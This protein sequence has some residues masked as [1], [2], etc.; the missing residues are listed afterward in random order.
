MI[1]RRGSVPLEGKISNRTKGKSLTGFTLVE[2][3]VVI[4]IIAL[5]MSILMPALSRVRKQ[6]QFV[7]CR[8]NLKQWGLMF[9]FYTDDWDGDFN[10][11]W[12]VGETALWMNALR[13]YYK[14][15]W[16]LLLCPTA[17]V[18][19]L[20]P[21]DMGTF[22]AWS[23]DVAM[24]G[25]G[26]YHYVGSY[27]INSWTNYMTKDRGAR[28]MEDF[29]KNARDT[30]DRITHKPIP[31]NTIPVFADST[32]HDAWPRHGDTPPPTPDDFGWGSPGTTLEI[33]HF[34]IDRHDA[35]VNFLFMDWSVR[36]VGLKEIWTLKWNRSFNTSGP[37]TLAGGVSA[38][39][40]P[41]WMR[42]FKDY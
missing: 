6:A 4:A 28:E 25:G 34:C 14:D 26:R 10:E 33:R 21:A 24:P 30:R 16:A 19:V 29:W 7:N 39:A 37:W 1:T 8:A 9:K 12:N 42:S 38:S 17:K 41:K 27:G 36:R 40:W 18:E 13:P 23:R 20:G 35:F 2:L 11:G 3:L 5:L 15:N 31:L 32:W 22:K